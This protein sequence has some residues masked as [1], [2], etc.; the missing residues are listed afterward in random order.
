MT[1][2]SNISPALRTIHYDLG[3]DNTFDGTSIEVPKLT[4]QAAIDAAVASSPPPQLGNSV[5]VVT[6]QVGSFST[7]FIL[8]DFVSFD[9]RNATITTTDTIVITLASFLNFNITG[10]INLAASATNFLIDGE[11]ELAVNTLTSRTI[12]DNSK[13]FDI[14]GVCGNLNF[15]VIDGSVGGDSSVGFDITSTTTNPITINAGPYTLASD[16][17]TFI[18][19]NPVASTDAATLRVS[20]IISDS[21]SGT[22]AFLVQN[23]ELT[24]ESSGTIT[25]T[26]AINIKSGAILNIFSGEVI[27]DAGGILNA[28]IISHVGTITNNGTI[29]GQINNVVYSEEITFSFKNEAQRD[30][31][32][33][34]NLSLLKPDLLITVKT[35]NSVTTFDWTGEKNPSTYDSDLWIPLPLNAGPGT[36]FLGKDGANISSAGKAMNFIT[37]YKDTTLSLDT[38]FNP[39]GS[40]KSFEYI[41]G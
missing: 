1:Y 23:G 20:S 13:G 31:F 39:D 4:A 22:T 41:H 40:T 24:V 21:S 37:A 36:L 18:N 7:G 3:G 32:F 6:S 9:G 16:N 17:T 35:G 34:T 27:V 26:T 14:T 29:N 12:G 33:S 38:V 30:S 25:V 5:S 8:A 10:V 19:F 15:D 11:Q 28:S 2:K